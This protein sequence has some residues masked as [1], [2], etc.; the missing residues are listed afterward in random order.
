MM[1]VILSTIWAVDLSSHL[2]LLLARRANRRMAMTMLLI[3]LLRIT[4]VLVAAAM[5]PCVG[6]HHAWLLYFRGAF[7]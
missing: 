5:A 7:R 1:I 4:M 6:N 2:V 3:M